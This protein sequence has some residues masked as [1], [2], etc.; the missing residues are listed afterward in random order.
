MAL[1]L[2]LYQ[3]F[4]DIRR[5]RDVCAALAHALRTDLDTWRAVVDQHRATFDKGELKT[6]AQYVTWV[7]AM[8]LPTMPAHERFYMIL[9]D[10][11]Q[12]ISRKVVHAYAEA[13]RVG[14]LIAWETG[15]RGVTDRDYV[16]IVGEMRPHLDELRND[17][18]AAADILRP[19]E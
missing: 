16:R 13:M 9:P 2:G 17:L 7:N 10:L 5:Q 8:K 18:Q 14:E 11:G 6:E 3:W 19:F 4:K 15:K 12:A 1:V